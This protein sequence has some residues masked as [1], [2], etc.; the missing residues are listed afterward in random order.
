MTLPD[1]QVLPW[2]EALS[3]LWRPRCYCVATESQS[4]CSEMSAFSE[5]KEALPLFWI[6]CSSVLF[7]DTHEEFR[8]N[9]EDHQQLFQLWQ[10][11]SEQLQ[12]WGR[13]CR[14]IQAK[15]SCC[16]SQNLRAPLPHV[17]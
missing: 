14:H 16:A 7:C 11:L 10:W 3:A 4:L 5:M 9:R 17:L 6:W 2:L 1:V 12:F 8:C 15:H 13:F